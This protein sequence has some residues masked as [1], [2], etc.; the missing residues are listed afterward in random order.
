M[1]E[2]LS[3]NFLRQFRDKVTCMLMSDEKHNDDDDDGNDESF[4]KSTFKVNL[5]IHSIFPD[6]WSDFFDLLF[7]PNVYF[8]VPLQKYKIWPQ[9]IPAWTV[10]WPHNPAR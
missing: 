2:S 6:I 1:A 10:S 8:N 3:E 4:Y 7:V 5:W 9:N